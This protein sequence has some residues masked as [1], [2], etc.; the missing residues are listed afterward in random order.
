VNI[1]RQ[2]LGNGKT[3]EAK[4]SRRTSVFC[5]W[6][7]FM[8]TARKKQASRKASVRSGRASSRGDSLR[9]RMYSSGFGDFFLLTVP[10]PAGAQHILIDC[11]VHAEISAAWMTV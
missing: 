8:S 11:G 4:H 1:T 2:G 9:V 3:E 5:T 7:L 10:T 6:D